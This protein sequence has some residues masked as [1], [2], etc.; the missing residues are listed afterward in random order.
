MSNS[1]NTIIFNKNVT[2]VMK[3]ANKCIN[4]RRD[5]FQKFQFSTPK[6]TSRVTTYGRK[7]DD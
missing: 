6:H 4:L 7:Q 2:P 5:P 1:I 3:E